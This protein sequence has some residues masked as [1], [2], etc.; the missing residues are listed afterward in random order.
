[1]IGVHLSS[2]LPWP[3]Q[4]LS[5]LSCLF[6]W[7]YSFVYLKFSFLGWKSRPLGWLQGCVLSFLRGYLFVCSRCRLWVTFKGLFD[8]LKTKSRRI[9]SSVGWNENFLCSQ[10][11][12]FADTQ[13]QN[14]KFSLQYLYEIEGCL[15]L[16]ILTCLR[17][18]NF[19]FVLAYLLNVWDRLRLFL[20]VLIRNGVLSMTLKLF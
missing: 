8:L 5:Y 15:N 3:S 17:Y 20:Y 10:D 9:T 18:Q 14:A 6:L 12:L 11:Q 19:V 13:I 16:E 1:M 2:F 4:S 7:K